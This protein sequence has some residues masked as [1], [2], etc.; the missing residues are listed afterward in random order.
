[1][2]N[3]LL[4]SF[5][6]FTVETNH[7]SDRPAKTALQSSFFGACAAGFGFGLKE[8]LNYYLA[9]HSSDIPSVITPT[10]KS[11]FSLIGLGILGTYIVGEKIYYDKTTPFDN[12]L[13]IADK[14]TKRRTGKVLDISI[15][16]V[17][18]YTILTKAAHQSPVDAAF[19]TAFGLGVITGL[20]SEK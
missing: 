15:K 16:A 12:I 11:R 1:M 10:T 14:Q 2:K 4:G 5:L 19:C 3:F 6:L 18:A 8:A 17:I 9:N 13:P 20:E 7:P